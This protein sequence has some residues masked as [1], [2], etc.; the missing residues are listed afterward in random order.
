MAEFTLSRAGLIGAAAFTVATGAGA[1][2]SGNQDASEADLLALN[3]ALF[4]SMIVQK[5]ATLF[6]EVAVEDFTVLAPGGMVEGKARA[7]AGIAAWDAASITVSGQEVARH[8]EVAVVTG[9]L[10]ID[11]TMKPVGRWGPLK[12]MSVYEYADGEW[13]LISRALTPCAEMLV[14]LDRC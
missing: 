3:E 2:G 12:H 10:D 7:A 8:S 13:R 4:Q 5:D 9:R 11:G 6:N 14:K 1:Q